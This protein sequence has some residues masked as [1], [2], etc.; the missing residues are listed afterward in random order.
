MT[1]IDATLE[2]RR[3]L[4]GR[5]LSIAYEN[6]LKIVRGSMQ[7]LYDEDGRQYLDA[8]NNVAHAGHCHPKVVEAGVR[9]MQTLNTNT[10]YLHDTILEY[11]EQLTSTLPEPLSVCYFVNSGSE[12][13]ELALRLARAHTKARDMIVLDHAYHG[14]TTTLIDISPYKHDGPGGSG[15]P[16]WVHK[17]PLPRSEQDAHD[18]VE[19]IKTTDG[20]C[21]FIAESMP[22]VAGQIVLPT[23]YLSGVYEA[24]REAGGVCIADE[25][26]TGYGRIGTHFWAFE[27]YG[28]IPDIVVLGKPIG[29]GHPIGAVITTPDIATS[30]DNGMEFFSTFGGNT[31]SCAIGLAVLKV[32]QEQNLQDHALTVGEQLLN[33][34]RELQRHYEIIGDVRGSGL[35]L[36][37]ELTIDG[38]PATQEAKRI[39][40]TMRN[41][42]ILIGTDGPFNSV[43]KIRP[44]MPF[45]TAD[46]TTFLDVLQRV[47]KHE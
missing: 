29:N 39:V 42:G 25:V 15:P 28:V 30:F 20:L 19:V 21:G 12:A 26:Q 14:N 38:Q 36:G 24:V 44:P 2:T 34:L 9:Q 8:Y 27:S 45:S 13:N 6:P 31:V 5:N 22:S 7:Y 23:G 10:R 18:V 3:R 46:A 43:L 37:V 16:P 17:V 11:A 41:N 1:S 4:L 35:F 47:L 32:V 33:G 40:N